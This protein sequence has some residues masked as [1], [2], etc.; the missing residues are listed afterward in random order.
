MNAPAT[1]RILSR[2]HAISLLKI[3]HLI[4]KFP[5]TNLK[6]IELTIPNHLRLKL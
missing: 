5:S 2:G 1:A 6:F 4:L 3:V